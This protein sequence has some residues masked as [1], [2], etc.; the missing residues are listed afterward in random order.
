MLDL[1]TFDRQIPE[2][3]Y[4]SQMDKRSF[5]KC[6]RTIRI[7]HVSASCLLSV[8]GEVHVQMPEKPPVVHTVKVMVPLAQH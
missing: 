6:N 4:A 2:N 7:H 1:S 5:M 8:C 3:H